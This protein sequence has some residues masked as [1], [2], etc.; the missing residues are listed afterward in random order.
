ME[1]PFLSLWWEFW[2]VSH[3]HTHTHRPPPHHGLFILL[4]FEVVPHPVG[5][6]LG[7]CPRL[8]PHHRQTT[9]FSWGHTAPPSPPYRRLLWLWISNN[10]M[11][12]MSSCLRG[13]VF[14]FSLPVHVS[15]AWPMPKQSLQKSL[16]EITA[17]FMSKILWKYYLIIL[18]VSNI[19]ILGM[20]NISATILELADICKFFMFL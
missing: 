18:M 13:S 20:S 11:E 9:R 17:L 2:P 7:L 5:V 10:M 4:P 3:T 19:Y 14:L 1:G 12:I 6:R 8:D 16:L 15:F